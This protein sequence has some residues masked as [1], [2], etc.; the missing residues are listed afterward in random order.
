MTKKELVALLN[1]NY[2]DDDEVLVGYQDEYA[3]WI[4]PIKEIGDMSH[5]ACETHFEVCENGKWVRWEDNQGHPANAQN[6]FQPWQWRPIIDR[7]YTETLRCLK[8]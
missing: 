1:A 3:S 6:G 2:K 7:A 8:V 5:E 4:V